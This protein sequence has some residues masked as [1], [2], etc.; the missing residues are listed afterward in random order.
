MDETGKPR[1][2]ND[3]RSEFSAEPPLPREQRIELLRA[4]LRKGLKSGV[5]KRNLKGI[6]DDF[7]ARHDAA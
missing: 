3:V 2:L 5:S 7:I 1:D 4:E 6:Y